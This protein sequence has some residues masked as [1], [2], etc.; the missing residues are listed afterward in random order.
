M[1]VWFAC[2]KVKLITK[3]RIYFNKHKTLSFLWRKVI[4]RSQPTTRS[5]TSHPRK[6]YSVLVSALGRYGTCT[7]VTLDEWQAILL[8]S[9][10]LFIS[11][12]MATLF[13][14]ALGNDKNVWV[15]SL[16]VHVV[17]HPGYLI[18]ELLLR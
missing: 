15:K 4:Q 9:C 3:A 16:T 7:Q 11:D 2:W 6:W 13:M 17:G 1:V 8:N 5:L 14:D 18:I 10:I 12:T